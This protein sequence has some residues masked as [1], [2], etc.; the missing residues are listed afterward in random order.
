MKD[1]SQIQRLHMEAP[2]CAAACIVD[3]APV[4]RRSRLHFFSKQ[5]HRQRRNNLS[6]PPTVLLPFPMPLISVLLIPTSSERRRFPDHALDRGSETMSNPGAG[7]DSKPAT[8]APENGGD[9]RGRPRRGRLGAVFWIATSA[10]SSGSGGAGGLSSPCAVTSLGAAA[11]FGTATTGH[12]GVLGK[13]CGCGRIGHCLIRLRGMETR[14]ELQRH[15]MARHALA[16]CSARKCRLRRKVLEQ[17]L[18]LH[19]TRYP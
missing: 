15:Q 16:G 10:A 1:V 17:Q 8:R 3:R 9:R 18:Q 13:T 11:H 2:A 6:T 5:H 19:G 14:H 4:Q 7:R 12:F